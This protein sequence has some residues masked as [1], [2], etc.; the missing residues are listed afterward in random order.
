[1]CW[2]VPEYVV[3]YIYF[4]IL[5]NFD[6]T[7]L[8]CIRTRILSLVNF[9][10]YCYFY[11]YLVIVFL[12][13]CMSY[14]YFIWRWLSLCMYSSGVDEIKNVNMEKVVPKTITPTTKL[15]Y[16]NQISK[17]KTPHSLRQ[18]YD[19]R[20][21]YYVK[22]GIWQTVHRHFSWCDSSSNWNSKSTYWHMEYP[23]SNQ[24]ERDKASYHK[25]SH[26]IT[27]IQAPRTFV[28]N[29]DTRSLILYKCYPIESCY[30][31]IPW[32]HIFILKI[33]LK[34][35]PAWSPPWHDGM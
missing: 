26:N 19:T 30:I 4:K 31:S 16:W 32:K 17:L 15:K 6:T 23:S 18:P 13:S 2:Y 35:F 3:F 14:L 25:T 21:H 33:F 8:F 29:F 10:V 24:K 1:M 27:T 22:C 7:I 5:H 9:L 11:R 12:F 28:T 34:S 20:V